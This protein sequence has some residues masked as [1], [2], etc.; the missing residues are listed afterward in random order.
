MGRVPTMVEAC[1]QAGHAG[2]PRTPHD[3]QPP[4]HL[5]Q[6]LGGRELDEECA[7]SGTDEDA[8]DGNGDHFMSP[9]VVLGGS[10]SS[11]VGVGQLDSVQGGQGQGSLNCSLQHS[12]GLHLTAA[13]TWQCLKQ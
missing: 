13:V 9:L 1:M 4:A 7:H 6:Q 2:R 11:F 12:S 10:G 8:E 3:L 5:H